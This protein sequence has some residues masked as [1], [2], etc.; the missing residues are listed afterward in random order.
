MARSLEGN[1]VVGPA[2]THPSKPA[3][4]AGVYEGNARGR[5]FGDGRAGKDGRK[6]GVGRST[7]IN[8]RDRQPILPSMPRLTPA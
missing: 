8:A 7:G 1:I 5:M 3:H 6:D 4:Q 2:D